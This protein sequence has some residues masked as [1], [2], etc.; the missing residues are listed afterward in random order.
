M[1]RLGPT[2]RLSLLGLSVVVVITV[3]VGCSMRASDDYSGPVDAFAR[4]DGDTMRKL[5][6]LANDMGRTRSNL[7]GWVIRQ[8]VEAEYPKLQAKRKR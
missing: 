6:E 4:V 1:P 8:Y 5:D 3:A 7:I 2:F